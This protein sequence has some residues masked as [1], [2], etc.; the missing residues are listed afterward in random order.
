MTVA[1]LEGHRVIDLSSGIPGGYATKV[2]ADAGADGIKVEP[3][4]GDFLRHWSSSGAEITPGDDGA[5]FQYLACS[6]SS[7]VVDPGGDLSPAMEL[8]ASANAAVWS[9]GSRLAEL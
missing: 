7:V 3:P 4:E 6:K 8:L 2:L 1:P 5:L 9:R